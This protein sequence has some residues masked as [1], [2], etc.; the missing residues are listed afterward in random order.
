MKLIQICRKYI[1]EQNIRQYYFLHWSGVLLRL[2]V[3]FTAFVNNF[4]YFSLRLLR[5]RQQWFFV[6]LFVCLSFSTENS[7]FQ[8]LMRVQILHQKSFFEINQNIE[9]TDAKTHIHP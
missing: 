9:L 7:F 1:E 5:Q 3:T 6:Y 4:C 2:S 8:W